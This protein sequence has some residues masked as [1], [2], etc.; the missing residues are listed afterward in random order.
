MSRVLPDESSDSVYLTEMLGQ[1][2]EKRV[3]GDSSSAVRELSS[4]TQAN[5]VAS[6]TKESE[7]AVVMPDFSLIPNVPSKPLYRFV[8]RAVDILGAVV[9]LVLFSPLIALCAILV[10]L[11]DGGPIFYTQERVGYRGRTFRLYKF[12]SMVINAE[13]MKE[14]LIDL[15]S[16]GDNR[17]FK[18][19][20]DPRITPVGHFMRR[21]SLDEVPQF[22]NILRGDMSLVGPRPALPSEVAM[23]ETRHLL[24]L[25]VIPG[26]TCIWQVSG[27]S[28]IE[29]E[30]QVEL[31][32]QYINSRGVWTDLSL[33][34]QTVPA[35]VRGEGAA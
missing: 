17:T 31:D 14:D 7:Q 28:N 9:G 20:N 5:E 3:R 21:M 4:P 6:T 13:A 19:L 32:S 16:H 24:R 23:Y 33:I 8:K 34:A 1:L 18:I 22:W 10:K 35:V 25:A 15:N 29:F 26:L 11:G 2:S 30:R 27:R 12:R